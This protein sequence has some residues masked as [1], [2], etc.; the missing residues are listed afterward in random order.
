[1]RQEDL[2][3][4]LL[5]NAIED[6]DRAGTILP[7]AD[8]LAAAREARREGDGAATDPDVEQA[9]AASEAAQRLLATRARMLYSKVLARHPFVDVVFRLAGGSAA[10]SWLLIALSLV[11]GGA[12]S[13][14]DGTRRINI[15][16]FPVLA[17]VLWNLCVYLLVM[18]GWVRGARETQAQPRRLAG[19]WVRLGIGRLSRMIAGSGAFNAPLADALGRFAL[20]WRDAAKPLLIARATRVFHLCAAAVGA[21]LIAGLYLRGIAFDYQAGWESTFLDASQVRALLSGAY[22]PAFFATGVP[23][24]DAA[25]LDAIRWRADGGGERAAPWIHLLA[26]S[27]AIFVV[28]PRLLL[29]LVS[30]F[31]IA[32][33]SRRARLPQSLAACFRKAFGAVGGVT[34]RAVATVI[35]CAY[36]PSAEARAGL[37]A[38]LPASLGESLTLDARAPVRYGEEDEFVQS[39]GAPDADAVVLLFNLA[40]TPEDE[41]HGVVLAGVRDWVAGSR[42]GTRLLVLLDEGPYMSRMTGD[43]GSGARVDERRGAWR[44]FV[45]ARGLP[46]CSANLAAAAGDAALLPELLDAVR[47]ALWETRAG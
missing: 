30:T 12:L 45:A 14:L 34:G 6:S 25:H 19:W 27:V 17:L 44:D 2:R 24:P 5:I 20:A 13:A 10:A 47:N 15:V 46:A 28:V 9:G 35:P 41:T 33:W 26:A 42:S 7:P 8:R 36:E 16:S 31:H 32:V 39:L 21:G 38:L 18:A 4:V 11:A 29:A 23:L 3:R 1:L 22:G 37:R 43:G 40:A